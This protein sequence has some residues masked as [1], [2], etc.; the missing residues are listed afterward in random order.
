MYGGR[1]NRY[2]DYKA[3]PFISGSG[4]FCVLCVF[5]LCFVCEP[6]DFRIRGFTE[7]KADIDVDLLS[8]TTC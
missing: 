4:V 5:S 3:D 2:C 8:L 6:F 7:Q 1:S